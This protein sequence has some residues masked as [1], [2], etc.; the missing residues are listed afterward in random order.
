MAGSAS[1][2][3]VRPVPG[4]TPLRVGAIDIGTNAIRFLAVELTS[5]DH[6]LQ[7]ESDRIPVRLGRHA[8]ENGRLDP[9]VV[10]AAIR[11]LTRVSKQLKTLGIEHYRAVATAAV[12]DSPDGARFVREV[13]RVCGLQVEPISPAEEVRLVHIG[14]RHKLAKDGRRLIIDVGGGSVEAA[15]VQ[16]DEILWTESHPIGAV[17]LLEEYGSNG[18]KPTRVEQL[19]KEGLES[20]RFHHP[21]PDGAF[22]VVGTGGNIEALADIAKAAADDSGVRTLS[23]Q[24]LVDLVEDLARLSVAKRAKR[25]GLTGDRADV[26]VPAGLLFVHLL[27]MLKVDKILVPNVGVKE[28]LIFDQAHDLLEHVDHERDRE[29]VLRRGVAVV[30]A[31][32]GFEENHDRHVAGLAL[33]LFDQ[34]GRVHK[35]P[36]SDWRL[37]WTA[38]MLHD[39]GKHIDERKHH[40]H[41]AYLLQN[42]EIPGLSGSEQRIVASVAR[43]HRKGMPASDHKPFRSLSKSER[44]RVVRLAVLL[45]IADALDREHQQRV[46]EVAVRTTPKAVRLTLKGTGDLLLEKWSVERQ[47]THFGKAFGR[48]LHVQSGAKA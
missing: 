33:Q 40:K 39:I 24:A 38:A 36:G 48:P 7:L 10:R 30:G 35:L 19:I 8:T 46:H 1:T 42:I 17:R 41:T 5:R 21:F 25:F 29:Q 9:V 23:R 37:L 15:L 13:R 28:G 16:D 20:F 31:R 27:K 47:A 18:A 12:R 32:F 6:Y 43:Y 14:A 26:I 11:G 3:L 34:L 4:S 22:T 44:S 2:S 45:R